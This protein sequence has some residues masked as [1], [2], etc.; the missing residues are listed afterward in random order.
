MQ[1]YALIDKLFTQTIS[2]RMLSFTI[3]HPSMPQ[4]RLGRLHRWDDSSLSG[5][6]CVWQRSVGSSIMH[7]DLLGAWQG[8][9]SVHCMSTLSQG[10]WQSSSSKH[11]MSTYSLGACQGS[12]SVHCM[13]TYSLGAWQGSGSVHC[14][15]TLSKGAWQCSSSKRCMCM[16]IR[17]LCGRDMARAAC[18]S[19]VLAGA[20]ID[21]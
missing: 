6:L 9:G 4:R 7:W 18:I 1:H 8:S 19:W 14:M 2:I 17:T 11:W 15:S 21:S 13:S 5:D 3:L 20:V 16:S 10:A 12:S